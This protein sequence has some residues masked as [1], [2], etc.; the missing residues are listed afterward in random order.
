MA[1]RYWNRCRTQRYDLTPFD[2]DG[3]V[4]MNMTPEARMELAGIILQEIE[5]VNHDSTKEMKR[6]Q[7][8]DKRTSNSLC[9]AS[10]E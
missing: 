4:F 2:V 1:H 9:T 10:C 5:S 8:D 7:A 3:P 6:G